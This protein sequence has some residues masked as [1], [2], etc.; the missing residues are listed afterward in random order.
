MRTAVYDALAH[1][2]VAEWYADLVHKLPQHV[3]RQ[4]A[5]CARADHQQ[6]VAACL[7]IRRTK[8]MANAVRQVSTVRLLD[9]FAQQTDTAFAIRLHLQATP[10]ARANIL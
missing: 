2:G 9:L 3:R 1:H 4:L 7:R 5:I 10:S 8:M 6:R